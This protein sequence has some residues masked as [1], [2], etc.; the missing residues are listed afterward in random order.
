MIIII[1]ITIIIIIIIIMIVILYY[2]IPYYI[3]LYYTILYYTILYY[4]I[5]HIV[6]LDVYVFCVDG[7]LFVSF[8][9]VSFVI[10]F[11]Y[12]LN[13]EFRDV[14]FEDLVLDNNRCY[15]IL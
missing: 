9:C 7:Q 11:D 8:A 15:L 1:M 14:V 12:F 3:T 13:S 6:A 5:T 10:L 4:T 2:T